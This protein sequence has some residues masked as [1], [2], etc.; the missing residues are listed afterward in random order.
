MYQVAV[1]HE[2]GYDYALV[3]V[4]PGTLAGRQIMAVGGSYTWGT[5]GAVVY[6]TDPESL[7]VLRTKLNNG[8]DS[9]STSL[10]ILL[11]VQIEDAQVVSTNYVTHRWMK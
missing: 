10:E 7:R 3:R 4:W 2:T 9:K 11:R 6:I 8:G 5:E 1:T